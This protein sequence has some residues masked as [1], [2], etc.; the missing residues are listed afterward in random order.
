MINLL[1]K[2][3]RNTTVDHKE[4][5]RAYIAQL[6]V[7][8]QREFVATAF[9]LMAERTGMSEAKSKPSYQQPRQEVKQ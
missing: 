4:V 5:L 3:Q 6:P 1:I 7:D 2:R 9:Q 8:K